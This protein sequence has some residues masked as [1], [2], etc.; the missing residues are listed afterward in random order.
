MLDKTKLFFKEN[1]QLIRTIGKKTN[2]F[3]KFIL[4]KPAG[5]SY[6]LRNS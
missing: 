3:G 4:D 6:K 2:Y 5:L 1:Q